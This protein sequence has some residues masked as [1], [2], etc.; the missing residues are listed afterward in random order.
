M[1]CSK[2]RNV[3]EGVGDEG[4]RRKRRDGSR[5]KEGELKDAN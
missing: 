2:K 5:R 1:I 4:R 3:R